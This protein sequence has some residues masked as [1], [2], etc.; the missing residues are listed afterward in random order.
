MLPRPSATLPRPSRIPSTKT[1]QSHY[2]PTQ[3]PTNCQTGQIIT[4]TLTHASLQQQK[5]QTNPTSHSTSRST[6]NPQSSKTIRGDH[7]QNNPGKICPEPTKSPLLPTSPAHNRQST[8]PRSAASNSSRNS[9]FS[10]PSTII[11]RPPPRN[12]H[13]F[14]QNSHIPRPH[15]PEFNTQRPP[16]LP[17][18]PYQR[19]NIMTGPYQQHQQ[20][21]GHYTQQVSLPPYVPIII[22]TPYNQINNVLATANKTLQPKP[23]ITD[24]R[25]I[26]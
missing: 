8:T 9:T 11:S 14:Y 26:T 12:N 10:R 20:T 18:P 15:N 6:N 25:N 13:R 4:Q 17:R 3:E 23:T 2:E 21:Q 5:A 19:Q 22:L 1:K 24:K 16:L 7:Y